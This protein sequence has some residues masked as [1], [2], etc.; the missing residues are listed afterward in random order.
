MRFDEKGLGLT[1]EEMIALLDVKRETAI[2][3]RHYDGVIP[4]LPRIFTTNLDCSG[5]QHPFVR[6]ASRAQERAIA[7]RFREK[8]WQDKWMFLA[9]KM[10]EEEEAREEEDEALW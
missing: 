1:P 7:R 6:G 5:Q 10:E 2:K 8:K 9:P 4:C 3:C